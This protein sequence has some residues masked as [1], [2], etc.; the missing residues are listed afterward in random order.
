VEGT[1]RGIEG[2]TEDQELA[3]TIEST[4]PEYAHLFPEYAHLYDE[5]SAKDKA[6]PADDV[7]TPADMIFGQLRTALRPQQQ[8]PPPPKKPFL[9]R[10]WE[11]LAHVVRW[12]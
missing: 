6:K 10:F 1:P 3:H 4:F 9:Q 8:Q 7:A 12:R 11:V 2:A 5:Q